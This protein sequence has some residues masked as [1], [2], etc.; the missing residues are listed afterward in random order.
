M[1]GKVQ[2]KPLKRGCSPCVVERCEVNRSIIVSNITKEAFCTEDGLETYFEGNRAGGGE[3]D[4][5]KMLGR[6]KAIITFKDPAG[7]LFVGFTYLSCC[8]VYIY[9][10]GHS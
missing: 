10:T 4:D 2:S 1:I 6:N 3:I 5:I 9:S 7:Q 8:I